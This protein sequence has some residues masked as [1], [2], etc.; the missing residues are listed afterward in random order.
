MAIIIKPYTAFPGDVIRSSN[1]NQ[2]FDTIYNDY[3]GNIQNVN[4]AANAGIAYSKLQALPS[5]QIIVGSA[6]NVATPRVMSGDATISNTGVVTVFGG[7]GAKSLVPIGSIIA[8]YDYGVVATIPDPAY[9]I[10]CAGTVIAD[11]AS[12]FNGKTLPDLSG[13]YL[14][15]FGTD[16]GGNIGMGALPD[17]P[18]AVGN[19]GNTIN[20][21]HSHTVNAHQH[22][23]G[24]LAFEIF[25]KA[26][27]TIVGFDS[28]GVP[29]NL[30]GNNPAGGGGFDMPFY[31]GPAN[32]FYYTLAGS[33]VGLTATA[34]PGTN[35]QLSATQSIQPRSIQ[36]RYYMR[37]K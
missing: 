6:A 2:N 29:L 4:V 20:I 15:G 18:A 8:H 21:Q 10:I 19:A 35:N 13:R 31:N 7:G 11:G 17:P 34:S 26:G 37:F 22:G 25:E 27:S 9:W 1:Y 33:G 23:P 36:C 14:V 30:F 12:P 32:Q 24:N 16:G 3:N 5:A 28:A